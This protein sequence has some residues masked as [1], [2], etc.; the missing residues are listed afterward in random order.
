MSTSITKQIKLPVH[1]FGYALYNFVDDDNIGKKFIILNWCWTLDVEHLV[2]G[3]G[4][5]F[6]FLLLN[7]VHDSVDDFDVG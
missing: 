2:Q 6:S 4:S 1:S 3:N 5:W 7:R